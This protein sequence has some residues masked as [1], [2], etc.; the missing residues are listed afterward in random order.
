MNHL[1]EKFK[2]DIQGLVW[3]SA[4]LFIGLSLYSY[5]PFDPSFNSTSKN[6]VASNWCG[7]FGSFLADILFQSLGLMAWMAVVACV[8]K[9][10]GNFTNS[11]VKASRLRWVWSMLLILTMA[12]LAELHFPQVKFF[13][14]HVQAG[15]FLG[16]VTSSGLKSVFNFVGV[17]II[18]W[19]ILTVL[20]V[21]FTEKSLQTLFKYPIQL[22]QT[23]LA[24]VRE[25]DYAAIFSKVM[26]SL[27]STV[28]EKS[29]AVATAEPK[30][31]LNSEGLFVIRERKVKADE[32]PEER[33]FLPIE[34]EGDE[35][36]EDP[37]LSFGGPLK[38][39]FT[40]TQKQPQVKKKKPKRRQP[41]V[42]NWDMPELNLLSDPP[43]SG[44]QLDER[45]IKIK[46]NLLV[47]KLAQ[48]SVR[49]EVVG[50]KP[51]P[52]V[53]MFEFKP[54]ADVK[55]SKIVELADDLSLA[56]SS[57]SVRIIAPIPGRNV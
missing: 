51:G 22:V 34:E 24:K 7:Y 18:L 2:R 57:E 44:L 30:S 5:N 42:E 6:M 27:R 41:R 11:S 46:S 45:E 14:G 49:G 36:R 20:V 21:F 23:F 32:E 17:A 35:N 9:A 1:L 54:A 31:S 48:F 3:L 53:T 26:E 4:S 33:V 13:A 15:G 52:A 19:T 8:Y 40:K 39:F 25:M 37:Q 10:V 43:E 16:Q 55:I 38:G 12:S 50:I 29:P 47:E 28:P 56:L